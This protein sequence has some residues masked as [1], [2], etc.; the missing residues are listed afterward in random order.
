MA[1]LFPH[2]LASLACWSLL[3]WRGAVEAATASNTSGVIEVDLVFPSNASYAPSPVL[4][5]VFAV[6]NSDLIRFIASQIQYTIWPYDNRDSEV[7]S[8][9]LELRWANFS[10]SDVF[11]SYRGSTYDLNT[12]GTWTL[13][14]HL[15]WSSCE[16]AENDYDGMSLHSNDTGG[17]VTFSTNNSSQ[18]A[19]LV[20]DTKNRTCSASE[21]L[22]LNVT[23]SLEV[24]LGVRA[25]WHGIPTCAVVDAITLAP[26]PCAITINSAT[27]SS[28]SSSITSRVCKYKELWDPPIS[29]PSDDDDESTAQRFT[30]GGWCAGLAIA[31]AVWV[32]F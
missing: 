11:F 19:D 9:T 32:S 27:A 26:D 16:V 30:V 25:D 20:A 4:P 22:A 12:E 10:D 3:A 2:R 21:G 8:G 7:G 5:V 14:W 6:H 24:E 17:S 23:D 1:R 18:K 29:C 13:V 28:I 15:F 31:I